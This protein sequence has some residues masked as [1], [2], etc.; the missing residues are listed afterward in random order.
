MELSEQNPINYV[1]IVGYGYLCRVF[2]PDKGVIDRLN[3]G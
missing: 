2:K 3:Y 1:S